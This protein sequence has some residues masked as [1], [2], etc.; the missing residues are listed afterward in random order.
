V[1]ARNESFY[2]RTH[3][4]TRVD[5]VP[6]KGDDIPQVRGQRPPNHMLPSIGLFMTSLTRVSGVACGQVSCPPH[7][8]ETNKRISSKTQRDLEGSFITWITVYGMKI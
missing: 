8:K 5:G 1:F 6:K 4:E 3:E 2:A 7:K